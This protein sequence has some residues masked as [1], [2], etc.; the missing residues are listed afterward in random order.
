MNGT[1]IPAAAP[2]APAA[3]AARFSRAEIALHSTYSWPR[4]GWGQRDAIGMAAERSAATRRKGHTR[5]R[6]LVVQSSQETEVERT[7]SAGS[8]VAV[9]IRRSALCPAICPPP[10]RVGQHV[11]IGMATARSGPPEPRSHLLICPRAG[12]ASML[13]LEW[14]QHAV[15]PPGSRPHLLDDP[16]DPD[17]QVVRHR[18]SARNRV[19]LRPLPAGPRPG[20]WP[21]K[22]A[23][24]RYCP[25]VVENRPG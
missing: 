5:M 7:R 2:A 10:S 3:A 13:L 22:R 16:R 1:F 14:L 17:T 12:W 4:A 18:Q 19:R 8:Y 15:R 20:E 9:S 25:A 11:A 24:L 21:R 6:S 23:Q